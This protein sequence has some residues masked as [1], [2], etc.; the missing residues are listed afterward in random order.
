MRSNPP[1]LEPNIHAHLDLTEA[2]SITLATSVN[3]NGYDIILSN[4]TPMTLQLAAGSEEVPFFTNIGTL[5]VGGETITNG[6]SL[7]SVLNITNAADFAGYSIIYDGSNISLSIPEPA[8]ATLSMLT[9]AALA[10][11]RRRK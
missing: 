1:T 8:T 10:T 4:D 3:M 2:E 7:T 11:R 5:T 6:A 9:L